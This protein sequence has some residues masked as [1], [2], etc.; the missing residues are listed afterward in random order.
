MFTEL[1]K[2]LQRPALYERTSEKFWNDEHISKHMLASHLEPDTDRASRPFE[3]MDRSAEW[4]LSM[5]PAGASLLDIGCGPGLYTKR[6]AERGLRVTGIDFSRRSIDY[7]REHD[8]KSEYILQDYLTL[9]M[10]DAFDAV[11]LISCDYGA[12][13]PDERANLLPRVNRALKPGGLFIFDVFTPLADKG[14]IESKTWELDWANGFMSPKPHIFLTA[15]YFYGDTAAGGRT[16]IIDEDGMR[17]YNL[18]N[19]YF[20]TKSLVEEAASAGFS[21]DSFYG[22]A[23]GKPYTE[24]S[25]MICAVLRK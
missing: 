22:D 15:E 24:D 9:D 10:E 8:A 13:I 21:V 2:Y 12:L 18:W 1:Y 25:Q 4:M 23:A 14:R 11:I 5:L 19:C 16:V 17:C 20:T 7:A 3:F 6:F